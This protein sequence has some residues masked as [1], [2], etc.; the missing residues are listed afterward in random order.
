MPTIHL[1]PLQGLTDFR[2]RK[3]FHK[4]FGGIDG[5]YS[6][7][8]KTQQNE[9]KPAYK[10]DVDKENNE[11]LPFVPQILTANAEDFIAMAKY[12]KIAGYTQLDWN[13]GCPYPMVAK[14][15]MGSGLI[16]DAQKIDEIL[17]RVFEEV[18]MQISI[19]IRLGYQTPNELQNLLPILEKHPLKHIT[20]HPR[21]G[22]Q[23]YKGTVDLEAFEECLKRTSH[24]I[25]YNGDITNTENFRALQTQFPTIDHWMIG[26]GVIAN[27][28]LPQMIKNQTDTLPE[29]YQKPFELFHAELLHAFVEYLSGD[30]H[31][32]QRMY[33]FWEYFISLFPEK[34]KM[35]KQ[36]KKSKRLS[37]YQSIVNQ[38]TSET[39]IRQ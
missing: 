31:V 12:L 4:H 25:I 8:I 22:K 18:E 9:L 3:L 24:N 27:P 26:R 33:T 2:F 5:Y 6:P 15:R 32:I 30:T 37:D 7:Y 11:L 17:R 13:L 38:I 35:L 1:A 39:P 29:D 19:K 36:I 16:N 10:R 23:M 28:F 20:I 14:R 21:L 34:G